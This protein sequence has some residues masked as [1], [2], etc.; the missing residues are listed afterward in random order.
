[1]RWSAV[2]LVFLVFAGQALAAAN[3]SLNSSAQAIAV[4]ASTN[5]TMANATANVSKTATEPNITPKA[6]AVLSAPI[7]H[8]VSA[9]TAPTVAIPE[10]PAYDIRFIC[11]NLILMVLILYSIAHYLHGRR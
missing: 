7:V 2:F 9:A 11:I 4:N 10:T 1:M 5:I 6:A 8:N 3:L